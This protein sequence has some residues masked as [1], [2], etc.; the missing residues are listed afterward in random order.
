MNKQKLLEVPELRNGEVGRTSCLKTLKNM[1]TCA[2][3]R[4][5]ADQDLETGYTDTNM[6][7]LD[8]ADVICTVTDR[9]QQRVGVFL[10]EL[11]H[12]RLLQR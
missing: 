6:R 9:K 7:S 10:D 5:R 3:A 8:H 11:D 4:A 1:L 12:E 2:Q